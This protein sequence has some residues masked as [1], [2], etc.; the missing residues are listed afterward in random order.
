MAGGSRTTKDRQVPYVM[1][2][3]PPLGRVGLSEA[4]ARRQ[5][6]PVRVGRFPMSR[7][8]RTEATD[9]KQG[10]MKA[11]VSANDD[12]ILGFAMIGP[13]PAKCWRPSRPR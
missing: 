13:R 6:V 2:T 11:I 10:F 5:G 3:D 12:R 1:F 9:E 7:V 4:G 8:L